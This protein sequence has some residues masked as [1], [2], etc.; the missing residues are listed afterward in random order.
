MPFVAPNCRT[1]QRGEFRL[2]NQH[3]GKRV[4]GATGLPSYEIPQLKQCVR[5]NQHSGK[6]L[7]KPNKPARCVALFA[8]LVVVFAVGIPA[9]VHAQ[10][11]PFANP[12][13]GTCFCG[14][15]TVDCV[16][17]PGEIRACCSPDGRIRCSL[18]EQ[19]GAGAR[20]VRVPDGNGNPVV[21]R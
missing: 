17:R 6:P 19:E 2:K 4:A 8:T 21:P 1:F 15:N 5:Q 7:R 12:R 16:P 11:R 9:T 18:L 14:V 13:P 3:S 10:F 20:D